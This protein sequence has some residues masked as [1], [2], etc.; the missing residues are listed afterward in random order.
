MNEQHQH[1][2][3]KGMSWGRFAAMIA[4]STVIMFFLMYQL[5]YT[6]DHVQFSVNRLIASLVMGCV[7]T[8]VML[9]FMWS[10]YK[11]MGT[12]IAVL[13]GAALLGL[14]LLFVNRGQAVIGDVT[15]MQSMIPHHSIAVNNARKASISDPRVRALAD[16]IIRAQIVEIA[17][18]ELLIADIEA[19]GELG[20]EELPPVSTAIT[21]EMQREIEELVRG[22][23]ISSET[24]FRNE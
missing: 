14:V 12:K 23:T 11:G 22:E 17:A 15:F 7:M 24:M 6:F 8:A 4:T 5:V 2:K 16:E 21:D 3:M 10:M 9:G 18:M 1:E 13:A 20:T 19:N